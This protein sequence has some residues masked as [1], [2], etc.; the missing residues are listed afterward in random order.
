MGTVRR[1]MTLVEIAMVMA[2][3][4]ILTTISVASIQ[5]VR[6]R[7]GFG[8]ASVEV[9]SALKRTRIEALS[10]GVYTAFIV[11]TAPSPPPARWWSIQTDATFSL[12]TFDPSSCTAPACTILDRGLLPSDVSFGPAAGYGAA[13]PQ[14]FN[15]VVVTGL[16]VNYCSFCVA[17]GTKRGA[18]VFSPGGQVGYGGSTVAAGFGQQFSITST[19]DQVTRTLGVVIVTRTGLIDS[20]ER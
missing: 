13:F 7:A 1:G 9:V 3:I 5:G 2:I 14:P 15:G 8:A 10:K 12:S 17:T 6:N 20:Y 19:R 16:P 4:A 18:L 11:E